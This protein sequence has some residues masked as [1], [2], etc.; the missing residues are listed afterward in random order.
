M[1]DTDVNGYVYYDSRWPRIKYFKNWGTYWINGYNVGIIGGAY[2]V[3][4]YYRLNRGLQW[5]KNEQLS[6]EEISKCLHYFNNFKNKKFDFILTHTCP[7]SWEPTDL[8]LPTID[9]STVDKTMENFLEQIK[10]IVNWKVWCFGH[11][12]A[13]RIERPYVE[14]LYKDIEN[15]EDIAQRWRKYRKTNELDWWLHKSPNFY[16]GS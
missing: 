16:M 4:K 12:H 9:Q 8:F 11:Y 1:F 3:D 10:D 5:F 14:Q 13:D 7:L 2:S 15:L 6:A